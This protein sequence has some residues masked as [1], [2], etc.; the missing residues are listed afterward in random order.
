MNRFSESFYRLA[1][2]LHLLWAIVVCNYPDS[3]D[4]LDDDDYYF[5]N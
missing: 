5:P 2:T 1:A 4:T 3:D